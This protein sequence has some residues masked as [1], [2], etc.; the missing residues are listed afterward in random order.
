MSRVR[1]VEREAVERNGWRRGKAGKEKEG[2]H[3]WWQPGE[4]NRGD[5]SREKRCVR[6]S[7][8]EQRWLAKCVRERNEGRSSSVHGMPSGDIVAND[9]FATRSFLWMGGS[10]HW[11]FRLNENITYVVTVYTTDSVGAATVTVVDCHAGGGKC[12][13]GDF[14]FVPVKRALYTLYTPPSTLWEIFLF[15]HRT[16][17]SMCR[18]ACYRSNLKR[19]SLG[20]LLDTKE[21]PVTP[22]KGF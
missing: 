17:G 8:I 20:L 9:S 5:R 14:F 6:K 18:S 12:L 21:S 4:G 11:S 19:T 15:D 16:G 10:Y 22:D 13:R 7:E 3:E 2:S 1:A